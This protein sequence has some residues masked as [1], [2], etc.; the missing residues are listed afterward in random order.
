MLAKALVLLIFAL[1]ICGSSAFYYNDTP[2]IN[3]IGNVHMRN[4][5]LPFQNETLSI[6]KLLARSGEINSNCQNSLKRWISGIETDELWA[7][8]FLEATGEFT[9]SFKK[10]LIK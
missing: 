4:Y 10:F 9:K 8:K 6:L 1:K 5:Y 3:N 2:F 7:L